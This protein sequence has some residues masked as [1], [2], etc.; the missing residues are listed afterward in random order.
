M[1]T[2]ILLIEDSRTLAENLNE[3][4]EVF[5][6]ELLEILTSAEKAME[7]IRKK[8]PDLLLIDIKLKGI[9][10]G[11]ELA[12]EIRDKIKIPIVFITSYSGKEVIKKIQH[13]APEGIVTKPFTYD[14]L[15]TSIELALANSKRN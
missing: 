8:K 6:Y 14:A 12:E 11:I 7:V 9:K 3:I 2:R 15:I 1:K 5:D 10:N 4:F 13:L